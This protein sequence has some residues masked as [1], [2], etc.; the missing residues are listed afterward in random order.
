MSDR[1]ELEHGDRSAFVRRLRMALADGVPTNPA[2]PLVTRDGPPPKPAYRTLDPGDLVGSFERAAQ[3]AGAEV[4]RVSDTEGVTAFVGSIVARHA[5]RRAV[6]TSEPEAACAASILSELGVA[7]DPYSSVDAA[8]AQLG[9]T[10]AFAGIAATGSLVVSSKRAGSR[11]ASLLPNVHL[12]LLPVDRLVATPADI[13]RR[14]GGDIDVPPS[15]VLITGPS[16][17][18]DIEQV[19]TIGV[20][21]PIAVYIALLDNWQGSTTAGLDV[22]PWISSTL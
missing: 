9:V 14:L 18:G 17:S 21:G 16:R 6:L 1:A 3:T 8:L 20:H 7:V 15:L 2:H 11:G 10:S 4:R 5:V 13:L 22:P 12:C 19:I